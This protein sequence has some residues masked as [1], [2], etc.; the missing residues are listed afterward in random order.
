M[1]RFS[2]LLLLAILLTGAGCATEERPAPQLRHLP[3]GL[4][5]IVKENRAADV[6]SAQVWV[7][8]GAVY[9]APGD[10]GT[11]DLLSKTIFGASATRAPGEMARAIESVG[12]ILAAD[13]NQ[14]H[15]CYAVT[16]PSR[17]FDLALDVLSDAVLR[18]VFNP[19]EVARAKMAVVKQ[20]AALAERPTD[21]A[22]QLCLQTIMPGHPMARPP[23][24]TLSALSSLDAAALEAWRARHYVGANMVVVVVGSVDPSE[25][26]DKVEKAF[27]AVPPGARAEPWAPSVTWPTAPARVIERTGAKRAT[28]MIAFPGPGVGDAD[29]MAAD[30]LMMALTNGRSSP[31]SRVLV[32]E[33]GLAGSAGGGWYTRTQP[34]PCFVWMELAPEN[35]QAAED[36]VVE[37]ITS[38]AEKPFTAEDLA[39]GKALL[40]SYMVFAS[41]TAEGQAAYDGYWFA[42]AGEGYGDTY[43]DRIDAV[44]VEDLRG[45]AAKYLRP[46]ARV[47]AVL[48]PEWI[49]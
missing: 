26:A 12:G 17:H 13:H 6:V 28:M 36:A 7:R 14:D 42:V 21:R 44:T 8:D 22:L 5:V 19:D 4:T 49:R 23:A 33:R 39:R 41:E 35:M 45:A 2:R 1:V 47:T 15:V 38:L 34:S 37:V 18:P 46:E 31:I 32:E 24:S 3:N 9:E 20:S 10:A 29:H 16:V 43:L 25:A 30:V 27:S 11:A 48:E 40:K